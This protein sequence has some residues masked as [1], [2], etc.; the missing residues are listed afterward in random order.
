[1]RISKL[2][3]QIYFFLVCS[4]SVVPIFGNSLSTNLEKDIVFS[5]E[6]ILPDTTCGL[7]DTVFQLTFPTCIGDADATARIEISGSP[8]P[9]SF[10]WDNESRGATGTGLSAGKHFVSVTDLDG[11]TLVDSIIIE[12]KP[13]FAFDVQTVAPLCV[14]VPNGGISISD[15]A[16]YSYNWNTGDSINTLS[17]LVSGIYTVTITDTLGCTIIESFALTNSTR[18][19]LELA[20][21]DATCIGM[22]NGSV[23]AN[24]GLNLSGYS[25]LWNT[26][27]TTNILTDLAPATYFVLA[28][29]PEGCL[30]GDSIDIGF[31][32]EVPLIANIT[33]ASCVGVNNGSISVND[34]LD[35][36]GFQFGWSTGA[37]TQSINN[38]TAGTYSVA[39]ADPIGCLATATFEVANTT[40]LVLTADVTNG[41]CD[42]A[43]NGSIL[44][45]ESS[46]VTGYTFNWSN[47]DST[48]LL[49]NVVPD[50]Y[51][52]TVTDA[53]GCVAIDSFN[54]G[55]TRNLVIGFMVE[56]TSCDGVNDGTVSLNRGQDLSSV[57]I[58][59]STGESTQTIEGLAPGNYTFLVTDTFG[60][61]VFG[62]PIVEI[63]TNFTIEASVTNASCTG[64]NDG[65]ITLNDSTG[66]DGL[67]IIWSTGD[68]TQTIS[69]LAAGEYSYVVTDSIGCSQEGTVVVG[70]RRSVV[71]DL[72]RTDVSCQGLSDGTVSV[73]NT[74][75]ILG[76][77][78]IWNTNDTVPNLTDLPAGTYTVTATD[79]EGCIGTSAISVLAL[80]SISASLTQTAVSCTGILDGT[81][82]INQGENVDG[83]TISWSTGDS[84]Q[85]ITGIGIGTYTATISD[86]TGCIA[87]ESI[88]VTA[89]SSLQ[90]NISGNNINC[91]GIDDGRINAAVIGRGSNLGLTFL[92]STND[93]TA[94]ISNLGPG[95]YE[96]TITDT[97]GCFGMVGVTLNPADTITTILTTVQPECMDTIGTGAIIA[98]VA[99][100]SGDFTF[101]W[102]TG[103]TTD[104]IGQLVA[105][106]YILTVTDSE[107]CIK[108][109]SA[110]L[111]SPPDL[112]VTATETQA[113]TC[114]GT[115]DGIAD[116]IASG[117]TSPFSISWSTGD[118]FPTLPNLDPGIYT[119]TV[120]DAAGCQITESVTIS[121]TTNID[122]TVT[123][124]N[125]AS[126][127]SIADGIATAIASGGLAP[128]TFNWDN[129][130]VG[131]T[132]T[133]LS[134]N[135]HEVIATDVNG[136]TGIGSV[137]IG[138]FELEVS[139]MDR[140]ENL[141]CNGDTNGRGTA[142]PNTGE[143]PFTYLWS[144]GDTT[145]TVNSLLEGEHSVTVTD[146][147][148]KRGRATITITEPDPIRFNLDI[149]P[150][151]C[152][153][154]SN[155]RIV[156]N[157]VGIVGNVL[158]E[159]G[160][161]VSPDPIINGIS[162]G[163]KRIGVIDGNGCRAD[164]T[165]FIEALSPNPPSPIFGVET[166]GLIATFTDSSTNEPIDYLWRFGDGTTSMEASPVHEYPDTGN[167]EVNLVVTNNC[168]TDS[169]FRMIRIDPIPVASVDLFFGRDTSGLS[170]Q[171]VSIPVTVGG[172]DG[173]AGIAGTFELSNPA[174]GIIQ[175]VRDLNI[176]GLSQQNI[177][178]QQ[179]L[180][181]IDWQIPDS[182]DLVNIP[183]GTQIFVIDILLTGA[184]DECSNIIATNTE[185]T[186]QFTKD[187]NGQLVP[188][189]FSIT[190]A[191][192]CVAQ[193]VSIA[194]NISRE[195]ATAIEG[196]IIATNG[197]TTSMTSANGNYA[198][199]GL[200]GGATFNITPTKSDDLLNG[201]TAFDLV[202]ILQHI[203]TR[204]P[205]ETPFRIIAADI[206]NSGNVSSLDL[207]HL[208]RLILGQTDVFPNN[209]PW[210][211]IPANYTFINPSN[212]L[213]EDF[214]ESIELNRLEID[215]ANIDFI[216]IKIGDVIG[217]ANAGT[218]R[219]S[220]K[221]MEF[222]IEDQS[223]KS[224]EL[225]RIPFNIASNNNTLGFQFEIGFD[226]KK[227]A[228]VEANKGNSLN[229]TESNLGIKNLANG[230]LKLLWLN[231]QQMALQPSEKGQ[232]QL[233]FKAL[234][235]GKISDVISI[236]DATEY[237][238]QFYSK[239]EGQIGVQ[240]IELKINNALT[241]EETED[242]LPAVEMAFLQSGEN[243]SDGGCGDGI[244]N[245]MDGLIDCADADC[246]CE[247]NTTVG[248]NLII[249]PSAEAEL[250][251]GGWQLIQGTW[252]TRAMDPEPQ[253]G[254]AY[255]FP[256]NSEIGQ[257]GQIVNL[258]MD[259]TA[260]DQGIADYVFSGYA[261]SGDEDPA[262]AGQILIEYRNGNDST[263]TRFD[264]GLLTNVDDWFFI[265]DTIRLPVGTRVAIINLLA[266]RNNG[267]NNDAYFDN[268]SLS[269]L[270]AEDCEAPCEN[271]DLFT[272]T[273]ES[274]LN[275]TG[276]TASSTLI[277]G[278]GPI[279]YVWS[280]GDS[281][282]EI[283][284]LPVGIYTVMAT[285]SIGCTAMDSIQISADSSF[286]ANLVTSNNTCL[287]ERNGTINVDIVGGTA[288]FTLVW[289]D[290]TLSGDSLQGLP[291]GIYTLTITDSVGTST[292]AT[293]TITSA[294]QI[295]LSSED[296]KIESET[297]P[298]AG[299]GQ[300]SLVAIGG[301]APYTY[302]IGTDT[303]DNGVYLDLNAGT[304]SVS[305]T[306]SIGCSINDEVMVENTFAGELSAEFT[307]VIDDQTVSLTSNVV[308]TAATYSWTF[309]NGTTSTE[310][311]PSVTYADAG[312][313]EI[314]LSI[315][316]ECGT[317][318][319]C[320][321]MSVGITGP[322][323][324]TINGLNGISSDTVLIPITVNN[325]I[326]ISSYQKTISIQDTTNA[327]FLGVTNPNLAGLNN[328]NFFLV[329]DHTITNVW[330]D[331][332]GLGQ[333]VANNT[334][335]YNL[336][337]AVNGQVD[338]CISISI[339]DN[340]VMSQV[341]G[342]L[343][344]EVAEVPFN[345]E[346][347]EVCTQMVLPTT[348]QI[349]GN[350]LQASG[351]S[352]SGVQI[353]VSNSTDTTTTNAEGDYV[354]EG[355][356]IGDD[357]E[358][359][360]SLNTP[361]LEGVSSFDIV[362]INRH[363]LGTDSLDSPYKIIAAD[364]NQSG[365]ISVFDLVL[366][367]R[368][369]L[370]LNDNFPGNM[371]YRFVPT[372]YQFIDPTNPLAE[373]FPESITITNLNENISNQDFVA[374]KI[375]DVSFATPT[376]GLVSSPR[377]SPTLQLE[378]DNKNYEAGDIVE[379]PVQ[380][381]D[382]NDLIGF[383]LE[384]DFDKNNLAL[385]DI[386]PVALTGFNQNNI[387][388][389]YLEQGKI[390]M[391]W[392]SPEVEISDNATT[393]FKLRFKAKTSGNLIDKLALANRFLNSES[394]SKDLGIGE[395][396]LNIK[397]NSLLP[398]TE[399]S[400]YP[401]PS[402]GLVDLNFT[403][404][405]QEAL[406]ISLYNF[407]GQLVQEWKNVTNNYL[408]INLANQADGT[409]LIM[410]KRAS[411]VE[412][413]RVVLNR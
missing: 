122:L 64:I 8:G 407:T 162:D 125:L 81:A 181:N 184:S 224:G 331:A 74:A 208:Q 141:R 348:A 413:K 5:N 203:L 216:A 19:T 286:F 306:D 243:S 79:S 120:S 263:L 175:G 242:V 178:F 282:S 384:L 312:A 35:V 309:G 277:G 287:G 192:I 2:Y 397:E 193:T 338:T 311:N 337:L 188:A 146:N 376:A 16:S 58:A 228:F 211:F 161:G 313:F 28:T 118:S 281:T 230:R 153:T 47:G 34:S 206:D 262:D 218:A 137:D 244:D 392:V 358:I 246:F 18:A 369:I 104:A 149:T 135:F 51:A 271:I 27:D 32:R 119:V 215:T 305:I 314:C 73:N 110:I 102:N 207:A 148:G 91:A 123:E 387:G 373:A 291:N 168:A 378:I 24:D 389:K 160:F 105:G 273:T 121:Q 381:K 180:V 63:G 320:Q 231:Q 53:N 3:F 302:V 232:F 26:G 275:G 44:L 259:S 62:A 315:T 150:P 318:T 371:A 114:D 95:D 264:S 6:L 36:T 404:T 379:I 220:P 288:P 336:M 296:S 247:C 304:F 390:Q 205:L 213:A 350:I 256:L 356:S 375:A 364:I 69:G 39:I 299:D 359:T 253:D 136:C 167:Y 328:D 283:S 82:T 295:S 100:G 307:A 284:N 54:I 388:V 255:F 360:P 173:V 370:G 383:Q 46:D 174:I 57:A 308:D 267:G 10:V 172:F 33:D 86:G 406:Q 280:T 326:N 353:A 409:Y 345:I 84:T 40:E 341:V 298:N 394:Y 323:T 269:R 88:E 334:A 330:F 151:G 225:I 274:M 233:A 335:I 134:P 257:L 144:T 333:S 357:Y 1:M 71:V 106:T 89:D 195:E 239:E 101:N 76:G 402:K 75:E 49:A 92:W 159:F 156:I 112:I 272:V 194:G 377:T 204:A 240:S 212:P 354:V 186:L 342:I 386:E 393:L 245:D 251:S 324:F 293:A 87:T 199:P 362:I 113:A 408:Q 327:R 158:Y 268:L 9:F 68:S 351:A 179:N 235:D 97:T 107:G 138:F 399:F 61:T 219:F 187:F 405:N 17:N 143:F 55:I 23:S 80:N 127:E 155:G 147:S 185:T 72:T 391:S 196:V 191:E 140:I 176:P 115:E 139:I 249:N 403:N 182:S 310:I 352:I 411:G 96:V 15:T 189:P 241:T 289:S 124:L 30:N 279:S 93:T 13:P 382:L 372:A 183:S 301:F 236:V 346:N 361:L 266:R 285:D 166:L 365:T 222:E 332:S 290:T 329:D 221:S 116:V 276:G 103:Q 52:V 400:V 325:F 60:C 229:L 21:T 395:V 319:T 248:T 126:G 270:I 198:V 303:T 154:S 297:C 252:T 214:P 85:T 22:N 169:I 157:A 366:I 7:T 132:V 131:D 217:E 190:S 226:P 117:G 292:I 412:V 237:P 111:A 197:D 261:R 41:T 321:T 210:R 374:I 209:Q 164:T 11:C 347:G 396:T 163:D 385:V 142:I 152:P 343:G 42:V 294:S 401:N 317:A 45:N 367:Q 300:L 59:W 56:N 25:Y 344:N 201:V 368:A 340:P 29:S 260:I 265:G 278:T 202:R 223:F 250:S 77:T 66:V 65:S 128:Y 177:D 78:Y 145:A 339:V 70:N 50:I 165:F 200:A 67:N 398:I 108:I 129:G 14:G 31:E 109:D 130:A 12:E 254:A 258:S 37:E 98:N 20:G 43:E 227:L 380:A 38:L 410:L 349:S 99:G 83:L 363:I 4:V 355:L 171:M 234:A 238:A 170:G 322:V 133:N 316:N 94:S 48:Q 90:I